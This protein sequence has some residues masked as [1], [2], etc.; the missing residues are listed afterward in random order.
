[1]PV[2]ERNDTDRTESKISD[3]YIQQQMKL[4]T[5]IENIKQGK[6]HYINNL[7]DIFRRH[8]EV[9]DDLQLPETIGPWR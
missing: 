7:S 2:D 5:L 3:V 8:N 4:S 6:K 9:L 1:M